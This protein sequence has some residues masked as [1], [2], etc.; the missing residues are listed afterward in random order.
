MPVTVSDPP[1][2][3]GMV[4]AGPRELDWGSLVSAAA[5]ARPPIVAQ[6]HIKALPG[7]SQ[8]QLF[9]CDDGECYAVKFR[10]TPHGDG[11]GIFTEQV[12]ALLGRLIDAPVPAVRLIS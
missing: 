4:G 12:V 8:A 6:R 11:H 10:G 2:P 9:E 1:G 5:A 7:G 3:G